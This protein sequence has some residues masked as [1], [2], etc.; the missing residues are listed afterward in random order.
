V[1]RRSRCARESFVAASARRAQPLS[2]LRGKVAE[3]S[4]GRGRRKGKPLYNRV[5]LF[6]ISRITTYTCIWSGVRPGADSLLKQ[7]ATRQLK[8]CATGRR[9]FAEP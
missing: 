5:N 4:P 6:F 8:T 7:Y 9:P 3:K 1:L 2:S